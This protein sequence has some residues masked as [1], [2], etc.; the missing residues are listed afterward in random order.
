MI[1]LYLPGEHIGVDSSFDNKL[2]QYLSSISSQRE[3]TYIMDNIT[4]IN[5]QILPDGHPNKE[6]HQYMAETIYTYL[7]DHNLVECM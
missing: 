3:H 6:G 7:K 1:L 4:L 5:P 2:R